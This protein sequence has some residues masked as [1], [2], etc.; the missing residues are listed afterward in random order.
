MC[1]LFVKDYL[2][3]MCA[4]FY[5]QETSDNHYNQEYHLIPDEVNI[6]PGAEVQPPLTQSS[7]WQMIYNTD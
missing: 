1:F 7:R 2:S 5:F 3:Y 6:L 4:H